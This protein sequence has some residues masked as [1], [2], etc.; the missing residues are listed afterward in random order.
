MGI[1]A[2][3]VSKPR[4]VQPGAKIN[5]EYYIQKIL[6]PFLKD[7]YCRLYPNGDAVF[8][9][10]S[11]PLHASRVTQKFLTDQQV[12]F[13][14]PEQWMPKSSDAAPCD[15]FLW[16]HLK[17]KLN[18]RRV[19]RLRGLQNAI[20]EEVKKIPQE[21]ILWPLKSWPK[22]CTQIYSAEGRHIEKHL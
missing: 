5:S 8:H 22:R 10:D 17:D 9:E 4:F 19:S 16:G 18:K 20:R 21:I 12:I 6:K 14:R 15:Y 1:S 3:G 11:A 2:N 13:L 7:D